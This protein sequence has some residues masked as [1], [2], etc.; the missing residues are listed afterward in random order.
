MRALAAFASA[1]FLASLMR[2]SSAVFVQVLPVLVKP[3]LQAQ[4]EPEAL[5]LGGIIIV[6]LQLL[7]VLVKPGLQAQLEP[8]A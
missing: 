6:F 3:E 2:L 5:A 1:I 4:L 8:D 7:P